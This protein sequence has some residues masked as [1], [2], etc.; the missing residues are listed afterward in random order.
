M[1]LMIIMRHPPGALCEHK[2]IFLVKKN[3]TIIAQNYFYLNR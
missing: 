3:I 1:T 2:E